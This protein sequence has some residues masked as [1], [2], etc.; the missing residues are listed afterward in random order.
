MRGLIMLLASVLLAT[1]A[2]AQSIQQSGTVT[3][4]HVPYWVGTGIQADGGTAAD[5]P[6][7]TL[8]VTSNTSA[9][10]CVSSGRSTASG[11]QQLCLGAPLS[12]SAII[13]LQNY[14]TATAQNLSFVINGTTIVI[15]TGGGSTIPTITTPLVNGNY[16]CASGT[17]GALADCTWKQTAGTAN[18]IPYWSSTTV[19]GNISA[20]ANSVLVTS[21]GS[22]PS[23]STTL[24]AAVQ[25]NITATGTVASGT[26]QGSPVGAAYGGLEAMI[27][28]AAD[29]AMTL[30]GGGVA[31][32]EKGAAGIFGGEL[33]A[34]NL[35]KAGKPQTLQK[36]NEARKLEASGT[37]RHDIWA[38]TGWFRGADG[39]WR[40]ELPDKNLKVQSSWGHRALAHTIDHPELEQ[41]YPEAF[42]KLNP[43]VEID[44]A[45]KRH[46]A[47]RANDPTLGHGLDVVAPDEQQARL[48][49]A[50]ELQHM[51]QYEEDWAYGS[52]PALMKYYAKKAYP[53]EWSP[54]MQD[55]ADMAAHKAYRE[56][57]GEVEARN[58]QTR[59]DM[60]TM[61]RYFKPP[62]STEDTPRKDQIIR[63][64]PVQGDPFK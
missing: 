37:H 4:T 38:L 43:Y 17:T 1:T 42:K 63:F 64:I 19:L 20:A 10:F 58:A 48:V 16:I 54:T 41:A 8:G 23:L 33:G 18:Q 59:L 30:A 60:P 49:A 13:S 61:E 26:W 12:S 32:I 50:H 11:R 22:V 56:H 2:H 45:E 39:R 15:P 51:V 3:G 35:A 24:P 29:T 5:S 9:G 40:F 21:S 53:Y 6:I 7:T 44:P 46:G 27:K 52:N 28:P 14:G 62:Y 31:N 25:A 55:R 57:A 36:L 47:F 34:R